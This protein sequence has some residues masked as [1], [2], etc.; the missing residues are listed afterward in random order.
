M[1][2]SCPG[3][4]G[5][6]VAAEGQV[7]EAQHGEDTELVRTGRAALPT[8][9]MMEHIAKIGEYMTVP[10]CTTTGTVKDIRSEAGEALGSDPM[11]IY[12]IETAG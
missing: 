7:I 8:G 12:E 11:S 6:G 5:E 1:C 2:G 3:A 4:R 10:D 9:A